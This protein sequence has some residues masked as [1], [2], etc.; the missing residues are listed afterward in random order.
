MEGTTYQEN[1]VTLRPNENDA[2]VPLPSILEPKTRAWIPHFAFRTFSCIR[3]SNLLFCFI[4][5]PRWQPLYWR[6]LLISASEAVLFFSRPPANSLLHGNPLQTLQHSRSTC[7]VQLETLLINAIRLAP[8]VFLI[9]FF[10]KCELF[11]INE[12]EDWPIPKAT[13]Q[14]S[15]DPGEEC[16]VCN[17][18]RSQ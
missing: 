17:V 14:T 10:Y 9:Y 4:S 11:V 13:V 7:A 5:S 16:L 18:L 15:K 6:T 3:L 1:R 2:T 8:F 12:H